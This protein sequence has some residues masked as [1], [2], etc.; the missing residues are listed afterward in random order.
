ETGFITQEPGDQPADY[1]AW[2]AVGPFLN[3]PDGGM[4]TCS[5]GFAVQRGQ[6]PVLQNY[7]L[8]YANYQSGRMSLSDMF[9]RYPALENAFTA[10]VA[11]EG[12]YELPR[13][14]FTDQVPNCHGCE[15]GVKLPE[16][17]TPIVLSE[18]CPDREA[19]P[20]QVTDNAYTWFDF[21]CDACTGV[22][23]ESTG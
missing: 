10:Q 20:K 13:P 22:W 18:S 4:I 2:S 3:V 1:T 15:T 19:V 8:D 14:G 21:D 11:Y 9:E 17:S 12:V 16:G 23:N 6:Y 5:I 7:R